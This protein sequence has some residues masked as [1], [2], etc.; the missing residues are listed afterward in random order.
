MAEH[1]HAAQAACG[2][3]EQ[4]KEK[5]RFFADA[6]HVPAGAAFIAAHEYE[7]NETHDAKQY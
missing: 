6:P 7:Q 5:K 4:G 2:A 1:M 3:A